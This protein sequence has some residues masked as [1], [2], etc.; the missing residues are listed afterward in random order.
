MN[1]HRNMTNFVSGTAG[2]FFERINNR[3]SR[4]TGDSNSKV[5]SIFRPSRDVF[6]RRVQIPLSK[7]SE[8]RINR[9]QERIGLRS[10]SVVIQVALGLVFH[11]IHLQKEGATLWVEDSKGIKRSV[12]S[13]ILFG[14]FCDEIERKGDIVKY[15][16]AIDPDQDYLL[17]YITEALEVSSLAEAVRISLRVLDSVSKN[18]KKTDQLLARL[19]DEDIVLALA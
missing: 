10:N 4:V 19:R 2:A 3:K 9:I 15:Q 7:G 13:F 8:F 17:T 12:D 6:K 18:L 5:V 11:L 14:D 16:I 1:V